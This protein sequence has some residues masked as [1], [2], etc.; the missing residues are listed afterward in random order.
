M[1]SAKKVLETA[2][3][4]S[5]EAREDLIS[6]L[7]VSLEP[8]TLIPEW[9]RE[10]ARRLDMIECGEATF[11]DAEDHLRSLRAKLGS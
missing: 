6:A 5:A 11:Y 7:S 4:L 10:I 3:A 1:I 2:L 8:T 9:Q